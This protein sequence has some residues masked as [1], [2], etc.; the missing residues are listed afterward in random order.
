[1]TRRSPE[2]GRSAVR[3]TRQERQTGDSKRPPG[4]FGRVA[5]E[6]NCRSVPVPFVLLSKRTT[7]SLVPDAGTSPSRKV[8]G[9]LMTDFSILLGSDGISHC[10]AARAHR[11]WPAGGRIADRLML[12]FDR[13]IPPHAS[14]RRFAI[15]K[16]NPQIFAMARGFSANC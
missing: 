2:A 1:V 12:G 11:L 13:K 4:S 3:W 14:L 10:C 16:L 6:T 15:E 5:F 9:R 8:R 7:R